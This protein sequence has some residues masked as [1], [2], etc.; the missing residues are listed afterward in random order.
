MAP[1]NVPS[2]LLTER[3]SCR[4]ALAPYSSSYEHVCL[5]A[6]IVQTGDI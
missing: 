3:E 4:T 5:C 2:L 1:R 6:V